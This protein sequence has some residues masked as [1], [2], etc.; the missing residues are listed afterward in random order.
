[1]KKIYE[2]LKIEINSLSDADVILASKLDY[3]T[4]GADA[5]GDYVGIP[6]DW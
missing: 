1:M 4:P 2:Q 5:S 3:S 6:E